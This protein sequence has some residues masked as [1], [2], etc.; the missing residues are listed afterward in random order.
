[1]N[2]TDYLRDRTKD[3]RCCKVDL[4][5]RQ[6][7]PAIR[8]APSQEGRYYQLLSGHAA[9]GDRAHKIPSIACWR[10]GSRKGLS[11]YH[12]LSERGLAPADQEAAERWR[13]GLRMETFRPQAPVR[14]PLQQEKAA[15]EVL[16]CRKPTG[17]LRHDSSAA[18]MEGEKRGPGPP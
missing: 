7:R 12:L 5:E 9:T 17:I 3:P 8:T 6:T 1:M 4:R 10:C 11:R 15:L 14:T 2:S 16:S 13:E 18:R